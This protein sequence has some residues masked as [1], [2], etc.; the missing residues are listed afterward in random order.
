MG[1]WRGRAN[2]SNIKR[3]LKNFGEKD[4]NP[5]EKWTKDMQGKFKGYFLMTLKHMKICST[6][7]IIREMKIKTTPTYYFPP[8][9]FAKVKKYENT[10]GLL[11]ECTVHNSFGGI[12]GNI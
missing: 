12:F 2:I 1:T 6:S 9:R 11:I 10:F 5:A 4:Q 3:R 7:L 8:I